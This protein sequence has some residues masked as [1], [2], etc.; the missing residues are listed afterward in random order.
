MNIVSN[1]LS[2]NPIINRTV[3]ESGTEHKVD[4]T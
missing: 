4:S 1:K 3:Q 2:I